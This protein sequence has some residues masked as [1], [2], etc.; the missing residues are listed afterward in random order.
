MGM[1]RLLRRTPAI[2]A[3]VAG[4]L[5]LVRGIA[6]SL[7]RRTVPYP[8]SVL[9]V[10]KALPFHVPNSAVPFDALAAMI[11]R[12]ADETPRLLQTLASTAGV[13][14]PRITSSHSFAA[15]HP[16]STADAEVLGALL[17]TH[18][19]D[20]STTHDYHMVYAALL[21]GRTATS[22]L[23][24]GLGTNDDRVPSSMGRDGRPG[25]SLRAFRDFLPSA[26]IH[27]ADIDAST[28]F[29]EDR[30]TTS[31]VDATDDRSVAKLFSRFPDPFDLIIDDGLHAPHAN[32]RVLIHGLDAIRIGGWVAI[33]DI[34][35]EKR[36]IWDVAARI[37]SPDRFEAWLVESRNCL[38]FLVR[39]LA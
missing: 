21:M 37:L 4:L 30:I 3:T 38:M 24:I 6:W 32:L 18:G 17:A 29:E 15:L 9:D 16:E 35:F 34:G 22:L 36:A 13:A 26:R 28:L 25:A 12:S 31:L 19:S 23:E 10:Q 2:G 5:G 33:E 39:R 27:G 7:G 8:L 20:K 1:R 14:P 11:A